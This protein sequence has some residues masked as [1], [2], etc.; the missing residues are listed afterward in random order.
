MCLSFQTIPRLLVRV[1][2]LTHTDC[3]SRPLS[4]HKAPAEVST[5][6]HL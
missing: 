5:G 4:R 2:H 1:P 3:S 6:L